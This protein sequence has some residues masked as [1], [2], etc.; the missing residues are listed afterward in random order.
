MLEYI[1]SILSRFRSCFRRNAA[2]KWF[3]VC[4]IALMVRSDHLGV[5]SFVRDLAP[6]PECYECILGFFRSSA[7]ANSAL[8]LRRLGVVASRAPVVKVRGRAIIVGDGAKQSK[9]ARRM[10]GVKKMS[11]ESETSSKAQ[12]IYG[13]L[14]GALGVVVSN[15][16]RRLC[17]PVK[18]NI[19]DGARE[20]VSWAE[21]K[22]IIDMS[23]ASHVE[24]MVGGAF[25]VAQS[26]GNSHLLLDRYFLAKNALSLLQGLNER[27]SEGGMNLVE[28]I[29][30]AKCNCIACMRPRKKPAA[31]GRPPKKGK[32]VRLS[33]LFGRK[34]RFSKGVA[35]MYGEMTEVSYCCVNLPW[36]SGLYR[37]LRFV[38]VE[39]NGMRSI[40]VGTDLSCPPLKVTELYA[41]RFSCEEMF[42][43]MKQQ[44]GAFCYHFRSKSCPR[45]NRFAK[46]G[47]G[48]GLKEI[49]DP[50]ERLPMVRTIKAIEPC[51]C[52][53][54]IAMG[55]LQLISLDKSLSKGVLAC[56][57]LRTYSSE[58]PSEATV[59]YYLR[60]YIFL[61]LGKSPDSF[62][63]RFIRERQR[64]PEKE[65]GAL[66]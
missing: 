8:A 35:W 29:T 18:T 3:V 4:V 48:N 65:P 7:Y 5:T 57:F 36:G 27:F 58:T 39:C 23:G 64:V 9:E 34:Q 14:L 49:T 31:R 30:K 59:M 10:P 62:V 20:I 6:R 2:F 54:C 52:C 44:I 24:Q 16:A 1:E 17:L 13:H 63:T 60:K 11:Q 50:N 32:V 38:P 37:E 43:E 47:D 25:E 51:V 40:L 66:A 45:L 21:A 15:G 22:G 56:R 33:S 55:M 28:T 42:R 46:K 41:R 19:Q 26:M 12:Y 53:S 61:I